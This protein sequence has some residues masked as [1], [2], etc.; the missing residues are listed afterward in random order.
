MDGNQ[1]RIE[2]RIVNP[3]NDEVL[4]QGAAEIRLRT[5]LLTAMNAATAQ[6]WFATTCSA[7]GTMAYREAY[8][9][10]GREAQG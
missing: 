1:V 8:P 5:D 2:V 6:D 9:R 4:G 10:S 7:V 3:D